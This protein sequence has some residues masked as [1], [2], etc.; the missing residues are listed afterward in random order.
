MEEWNG[1]N[2]N[3]PGKKFHKTKEERKKCYDRNNSR[4]RDIYNHKKNT[5]LLI[6]VE[7]SITEIEKRNEQSPE[8]ILIEA[9]DSEIEEK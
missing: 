6:S 5:G 2:L 8:D 9:I 3:H 7:D 1:A 4:Q